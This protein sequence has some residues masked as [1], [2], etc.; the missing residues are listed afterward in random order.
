MDIKEKLEMVD[1]LAERYKAP[2]V[3]GEL[4]QNLFCD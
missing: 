2:E 4:A 1:T 3:Q